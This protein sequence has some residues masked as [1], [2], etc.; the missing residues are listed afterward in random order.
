MRGGYMAKRLLEVKHLKKYFDAKGRGV[1]HAV[2]D[3]SFYINE[4]ETL[5]LVGESGCG[6]STVGNVL[7]NLLAATDGEA[8]LDGQNILNLDKTKRREL[9][10][11]MQIVFQDPYSSLNPK[12]SVRN[13]LSEPFLIGK[14]AQGAELDKRLS[15]L[16]RLTRIPRDLLNKFPHELDGGRRQTVGIAR[17]LALN[18][19]LIICDEP[20]SALDVSIQAQIINLLMDLQKDRNLT[21]LFISHDLSVVKHISSRIIV[22]YL[23]VI[24]ETAETEK[25]FENPLHPYTK[26]LLSAVPAIGR[27]KDEER[28]ILEGDVPSPIN[29]AP[30]CRFYKRCWMA[31]ERCAKEM[32]VLE[33]TENTGHNVACHK[34]FK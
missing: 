26:A 18:P 2:D 8:F 24:V 6:K 31:E 14:I 13:I 30:G 3:V 28:I 7:V 12:Q 20:V 19:K 15:D 10:S 33:D 27:E 4:G 23:G 29:P 9:A 25:L 16:C 21:Y 1:L 22:M 32:P 17:A 11:V 5:G 34:A